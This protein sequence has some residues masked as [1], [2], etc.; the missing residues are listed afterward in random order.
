MNEFTFMKIPLQRRPKF[1]EKKIRENL[2][3]LF[4]RGDLR[5]EINSTLD[6]ISLENVIQMLVRKFRK[7]SVIF[8]FGRLVD[9]VNS[10]EFN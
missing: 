2:N 1:F 6:G 8:I 9:S 4:I 3:R 10:F 5:T 7:K